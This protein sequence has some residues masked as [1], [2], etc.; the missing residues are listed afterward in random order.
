MK[1][2]TAP[3]LALATAIAATVGA[4]APA[5]AQLEEVIVTAQ[6][7]E[8]SLQDV[9]ASVSVVSGESIHDF[10]GSGENI[11]ALA[12]R[13]PSLQIESSNGR[14]SPRFYIRGL[15]NT[16][17]DVNANQPVSLI[18]DDVALENSVLKSL[19]LFD[20]SRVEVLKGPQGTLF[21][22]NT[23][24]GVVK[25]DTVRPDDV[26]EGY[27]NFGYGSRETANAEFAIG[28]ALTDTI[29]SRLSLR[30]TDRGDWIDNELEG[31]GDDF[32]GFDEFAYRLQFLIEP[33]DELTALIKFHGFDQDG[34]Q[35]QIFYANALKQGKEGTRSGFDEEKVTQDSGAGFEMEH[36]GTSANIQYE[37]SSFTFTSITAYDTVDSFSRAD[38]DGG[39][40]TFNPAE[41]G[42]LGRNAFGVVA[43]GDGLD[44]HYQFSQEFRISGD[45]D[46][47]FY[48]VG[49][50][51]FDEDITIRSTDFNASIPP[52]FTAP[53]LDRTTFVEQETT[54]IAV[55]GQVEY[56]FTDALAVTGGL[57][58]TDDDK[59]LE[60]VP[61][62]NSTAFASTIAKDDDYISWDLAIN[63]DINGDWSIYSRVGEASRGPVTIGR[64]GFTSSAE[65]ETLT[66]IEAGFKSVLF[67]GA[68]RWNATIYAFEIED[69]QLT[70]TGG[71]G[72][73]NTLVNADQ[74][75]GYGFETDF[76]WL[77]NENLRFMT[78]LSYN[79]T[80][81]DDS[82]L[83][84]SACTSTPSCTMKDPIAV[85]NN[86]SDFGPFDTVFV[87]G[88]PLP[89]SPEWLFNVALSYTVPL[90]SGADLYFNTDWNYRDESNIFLYEA[91]EYVAEERWLGGVRIGYKNAADNLDIALVGRNIT[92][93]VT[94]DGGID[95]LNLTAFVN[96]PAFWGVEVGYTF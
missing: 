46:E 49:L 85:P 56:R 42:D 35:P 51:Y 64:F 47:L 36:F 37:F 17:F 76:E 20:I 73:F 77:I 6:K 63:Y 1:A 8:Q 2:F 9:P 14:Q 15:G 13:V 30:Y 84:I 12:G 74:T 26:T 65:T 22:R 10:V 45:S 40:V 39:L 79:D 62:A 34:S 50:F 44:D 25:V 87:D 92:D 71:F 68:A 61:G 23:P 88:N 57:R 67:D 90:S 41:F 69:Q 66:S 60:V 78:N 32:G 72:N 59:D 52:D 3:K 18:M 95:F 7:R 58:Y 89:R 48:Q 91:V 28:G 16:D 53:T 83:T 55:F 70:A 38:I 80:E 93:E 82:D 54:S 29:S 75:N 94:V 19:P 43:S 24:A 33:S 31:S 81:I 11:R 4:T 96:E 27:L 5:M 86:P 21:G